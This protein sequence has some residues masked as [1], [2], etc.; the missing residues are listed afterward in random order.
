MSQRV[1]TNIDKKPYEYPSLE[2]LA[3][4][5][6]ED[7]ETSIQNYKLAK[8]ERFDAYKKIKDE[9]TSLVKS[10]SEEQNQGLSREENIEILQK[11][12]DKEL[13]KNYSKKNAIPSV[14]EG[15]NGSI[16]SKHKNKLAFIFIGDAKKAELDDKNSVNA[17]KISL[18]VGGGLESTYKEIDPREDK[19]IGP[20]AQVHI[21]SLSDVDVSGVLPVKFLKNRSAIRTKADVLEFSASEAVII[22]SLGE[23]YGSKGHR[24]MT[25]GGV[26]I[27]S[28]QNIPGKELKKSEPMV[29]GK[30]LSDAIN[31]LTEKLGEINSTIVSMNEDIM[32]LKVSLLAHVHPVAGLV[33]TPSADLALGVTPTMVSKTLLNMMNAYSSLVNL[34]LLKT[35]R[36]TALSPGRFLSDFNK[37]N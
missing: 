9:Q 35:N 27:I 21:T 17:P 30:K 6:K 26:H 14:I 15:D 5:S 11:R 1:T 33:T 37:V 34:E 4:L 8:Q 29:L 25:P 20:S 13:E 2:S 28:G 23:A 24:I 19:L 31:E 18:V 36:L 16:V 3:K 12:V 7:R 22:R 32:E 10:K